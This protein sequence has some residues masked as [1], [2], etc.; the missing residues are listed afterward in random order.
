MVHTKSSLR[1]SPASSH[2]GA[3]DTIGAANLR[4][5]NVQ[6]ELLSDALAA[7][8]EQEPNAPMLQKIT[9]ARLAET[10]FYSK[11]HVVSV[12]V[13]RAASIKGGLMLVGPRGAATR[14]RND[15]AL[16]PYM[17]E[18]EAGDAA[19]LMC[20]MQVQAVYRVTLPPGGQAAVRANAA[21][22]AVDDVPQQQQQ[23]QQDAAQHGDG[24]HAAADLGAPVQQAGAVP[25]AVDAAAE[26]AARQV[27]IAVGQMRELRIVNDDGWLCSTFC[28]G[29]ALPGADAD[30]APMRQVPTM[31][32]PQQ[33]RP[34][35][36]YAVPVHAIE[37][38]LVCS[39]DLQ[40]F[41]AYSK[42]AN[43]S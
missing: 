37:C 32:A 22:D 7:V 3:F 34:A 1:S 8:Q 20:V 5:S 40:A 28:D 15:Q 41:V 36:L 38:P 11:E 35:Y 18:T 16:L 23:Q 2:S 6:R 12:A 31:M 26:L 29:V 19:P 10:H 43:H 39:R 4:E 14:K 13:G 24:G 9:P 42:T 33:G 30:A 21:D 27:R 17:I 25:A